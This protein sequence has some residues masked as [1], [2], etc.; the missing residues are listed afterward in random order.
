M[1]RKELNTHIEKRYSECC[2]RSQG[3]SYGSFYDG[4]VDCY[5]EQQKRIEKL[6]QQLSAMEKGTCDVCK[7]KDAE[8]YEKRIAELIALINAERKR[9]EECDDVHLRKITELEKENAELK[10]ARDNCEEQFQDK[11]DELAIEV[12]RVIRAKEIIREFV[13]WAN[14]QGNSKCPSFKSIQDKAEQFLSEVKK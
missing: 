6:E 14:W 11:V 2:K 8:F 1:T 13:E 9:Q 5:C 3:L 4:Y 7:V 12:D 10:I